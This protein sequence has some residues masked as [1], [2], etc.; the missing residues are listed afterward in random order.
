MATTE[1]NLFCLRPE[2]PGIQL[3]LPK[4]H[5]VRHSCILGIASGEA[6]SGFASPAFAYDVV[7]PP[8]GAR[9][10]L[11]PVFTVS[12]TATRE[13]PESIVSNGHILLHG[14]AID[15]PFRDV[16]EGLLGSELQVLFISL[17]L[18]FCSLPGLFCFSKSESL[19]V[20]VSD[21]IVLEEKSLLSLRATTCRHAWLV[22]HF[23]ICLHSRLE[24]WCLNIGSATRDRRLL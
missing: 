2:V 8:D 20:K 19:L 14:C 23:S 6:G 7:G 5:L 3:H 18:S 15:A 24:E 22:S 12:L 17:I 21:A 1:D 4:I 11:N 10:A 16:R 13:P 9:R